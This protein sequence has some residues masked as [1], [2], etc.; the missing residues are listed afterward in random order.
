MEQ[1]KILV[2]IDKI[3]NLADNF[4]CCPICGDE[5]SG[6]KKCN[7][8][9]QKFDERETAIFFSRYLYKLKQEGVFEK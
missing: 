8:C 5:N 4:K 6:Y 1:K 3:I 9:G 2:D 7:H